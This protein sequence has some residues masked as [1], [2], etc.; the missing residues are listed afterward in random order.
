MTTQEFAGIIGLSVKE[1]N[2]LA[3]EGFIHPEGHNQWADNAVMQYTEALRA[4]N[5]S[6]VA[7][8]KQA[9][10]RADEAGEDKDKGAQE[11]YRKQ[12]A[13]IA[14]YQA[15]TMAGRLV[16]LGAVEKFLVDMV[17]RANSRLD[18]LPDAVAANVKPLLADGRTAS[19][20]K[21]LVSERVREAQNELSEHYQQ[22]AELRDRHDEAAYE[23]AGEEDS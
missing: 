21:K 5:R 23:E 4:K 8:L 7:Q 22:E 16:S 14:R 20:V 10:R 9:E 1:V 6:L 13:R 3:R 17:L 18:G 15:D 19:E 12:K 11:E 2:N